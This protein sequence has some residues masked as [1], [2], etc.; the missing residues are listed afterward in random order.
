MATWKKILLNV[1][2][3]VVTDNITNGAVTEGKIGTGAVTVEK[4]GANAVT[5]AKI[6]NSAV[7]L[8]KLENSSGQTLI[9]RSASEGGAFTQIAVGG[10][11]SFSNN[12]LNGL[13]TN[14]YNPVADQTTI[15]Y[16]SSYLYTIGTVQN[17]G[18]TSTPT[19]GGLT[20][21][22]DLTVT[23]TTVSINT[24]NLDVSDKVIKIANV[25][26]NSS[27]AAQNDSGLVV[28]RFFNK[29]D[30]YNPRLLWNT[31][32]IGATG[33]GVANKGDDTDVQNQPEVSSIWGIVAVQTGTTNP[34]SIPAG[35]IFINTNTDVLV[36]GV[37]IGS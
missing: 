33:W 5:T 17:I 15:T 10:N 12:I 4:I 32:T 35:A 6:N 2:D 9:G 11:L 22:G 8:A 25:S 28:D 1:T 19:F 14:S 37:F 3:S 27:N 24:S 13:Q 26:A 29:G 36:A 34:S 30:T 23:G 31:A 18:T 16:V 7:T 21:N 20:V